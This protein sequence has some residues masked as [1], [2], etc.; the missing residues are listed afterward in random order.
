MCQFVQSLRRR[1]SPRTVV[2]T[3]SLLPPL[4]SWQWYNDSFPG[5]GGPPPC[6][7]PPASS[8][9]HQGCRRDGAAARPAGTRALQGAG[10]G[11]QVEAP[12]WRRRDGAAARPAGTRALQMPHRTA[13][14]HS[15]GFLSAL[16]CVI[17]GSNSARGT[18]MRLPQTTRGMVAAVELTKPLNVRT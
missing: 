7:G 5:A 1:K 3:G 10:D 9:D 12:I 15:C 2:P 6:T 11:P 13:E 16:I 17:C 14:D 4:T 8:T 18:Y